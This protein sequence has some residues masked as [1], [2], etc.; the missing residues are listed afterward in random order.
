MSA[1][2]DTVLIERTRALIPEEHVEQKRMF[3]G[4]CF[5]VNGNMLVCISKRGLMARVGKEQAAEALSRPHA[6]PCEPSGR[7]MPGFIRVEPEGIETDEDLKSW[8]NLARNYVC[9]LPPN[10]AKKP[11]KAKSG[12]AA[13]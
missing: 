8:V 5:M 7:P 1:L 4:T 12:K 11:K 2:M 3:G 10:A 13:E 9:A 6:S